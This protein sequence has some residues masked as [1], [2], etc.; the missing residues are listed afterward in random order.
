MEFERRNERSKS[1]LPGLHFKANSSSATIESYSTVFVLS[2]SNLQFTKTL[3]SI[4]SHKQ[5][6]LKM[7]CSISQMTRNQINSQIP[8]IFHAFARVFNVK[9][10]RFKFS[11]QGRERERNS[12]HRLIVLSKCWVLADWENS[13]HIRH[14]NML[15]YLFH[16]ASPALF[17]FPLRCTRAI[18]PLGMESLQ[19]LF[20]HFK[21]YY[22][23][24]A[25]CI[26]S[27]GNVSIRMC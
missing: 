21:N 3:I 11:V 6:A 2:H 4:W 10:F 12:R 15:G 7:K 14:I 9:F 22:S 17:F 25:L 26:C 24:Y 13:L 20:M 27:V 1:L 18:I 5:S 16:S 23:L 19:Q 8:F